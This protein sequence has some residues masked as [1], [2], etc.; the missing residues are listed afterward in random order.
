MLLS[1]VGSIGGISTI[2][3][4]MALFT[5][6]SITVELVSQVTIVPLEGSVAAVSTLTSGS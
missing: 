6:D 4:D 3:G 1:L 5:S 2:A